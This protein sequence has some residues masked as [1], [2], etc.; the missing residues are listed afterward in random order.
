MM[1]TW[2]LGHVLEPALPDLL[3]QMH[4]LP[5]CCSNEETPATSHSL[6][7]ESHGNCLD[8]Y[9]ENTS[10]GKEWQKTSQT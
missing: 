6:H 1:L 5:C 3:L 4:L 2:I 8:M 9:A 10:K 7:Q